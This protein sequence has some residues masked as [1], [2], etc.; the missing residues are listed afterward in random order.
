VE[1]VNGLVE[2]GGT[3]KWFGGTGKWFGGTGK[4]CNIRLKL[5]R[6]FV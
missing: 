5:R 3:G 6:H 4:S 1:Q 2:L